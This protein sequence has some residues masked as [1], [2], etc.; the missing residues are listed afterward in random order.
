MIFNP[1]FPYRFVHMVTAAYLTTAFVVGGVGGYY[2]WRGLHVKHARIMLGM[3]MIMAVFVAPLQ[4]L[5]GDLHGLNT[6]KHQP[7]KVAAMEGIWET[8][9]GAPD[10][11]RLAGPGGRSAT[12]FAIE[13]PKL[14]SLILT[15]DLDGEVKGLKD[16]P[17]ED[18]PPVAMVFWSFR[19]MVGMGMLMIATG[20]MALVLY[21]RKAAVRRRAGFSCGAW[22]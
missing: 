10:A 3:A 1:S 12:R 5:F 19:I 14:S 2:L 22:P 13:I 9:R 4:L 15:H 7:A 16:W 11:F 8:E 17:R 18:R 21:L 20:V 6:F